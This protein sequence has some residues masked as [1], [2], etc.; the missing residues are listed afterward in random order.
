VWVG[1]GSFLTC[2]N[3]TNH[4]CQC[5]E[6]LVQAEAVSVTNKG[7][8]SAKVMLATVAAKLGWIKGQPGEV[9]LVKKHSQ[10]Q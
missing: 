4:A 1:Y 5:I 8:K 6:H 7:A 10:R 9:D 2:H 3:L